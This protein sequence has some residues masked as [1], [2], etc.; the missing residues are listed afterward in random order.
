LILALAEATIWC[1]LPVAAVQ[2]FL[3]FLGLTMVGF[4]L[5]F[6]ALFRQD[7]QFPDFAST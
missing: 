1:W 2:W 3:V 5:A 6:F 7:R 4:G